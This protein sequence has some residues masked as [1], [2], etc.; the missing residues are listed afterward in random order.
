MP[1]YVFEQGG[2]HL[3]AQY[4]ITLKSLLDNYFDL[5]LNKY[6]IF[7]E[8]YRITLN[9][10]LINYYLPYEI[11]METAPLF[12][13]RL[14]QA[15]ALIM[16]LYNQ[17]YEAESYKIDPLTNFKST[18]NYD[19]NRG[20]KTHRSDSAHSDAEN[21]TKRTDDNVSTRDTST[22]TFGIRQD[23][24]QTNVTRQDINNGLYASETN[25]ADG[26]ENERGTDNRNVNEDNTG[27]ADSTLDSNINVAT[28]ED[29][30]RTISGYR[31]VSPQNLINE[32]Y[33]SFVNIDQMIIE[34][35]KIRE[36]FMLVYHI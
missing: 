3:S 28:T 6:P 8:N 5:G 14:N 18:E 10:K 30:I 22:D 32:L 11:G 23:T 20:D 33:S 17:Y 26:T 21:N 24:P 16:P 19:R 31:G 12:K 27:R 35:P 29:Y 9:T 36:C 7:D 15:M 4:T 25:Q 1:A 34:D 2:G 13:Q